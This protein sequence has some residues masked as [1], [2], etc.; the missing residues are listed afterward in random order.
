L[1]EAWKVIVYRAGAG[2]KKYA[3]FDLIATHEC[4]T[5]NPLVLPEY[6]YGGV[7]FRGHRGW[8]PKDNCVFLTSEGKTRENGHATRARWCHIGGKIDGETAGIAILDHPGN[9]RAPQPMRINPDQPFFCYAP[10]LAGQ[11][12][13]K[14]G[15]RYVS[16]YRFIVYDGPPDKDE[17]DRLW[18][19]YASPPQVTIG[20]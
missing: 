1:N 16:R 5:S 20:R 11:F 2:D 7:G 3:I 19:E 18:N 4:A 13:I 9:F 14:P 6:R 10:P 17:L 12:E 15:Q 8:L